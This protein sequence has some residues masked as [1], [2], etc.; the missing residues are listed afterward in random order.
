MPVGVQAIIMPG[1]RGG[2]VGID[3]CLLVINSPWVQRICKQ[4]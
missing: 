2:E 3:I 1:S 4:S